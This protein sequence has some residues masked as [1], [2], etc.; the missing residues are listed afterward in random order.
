MT[1]EGKTALVTGAGSGIGRATAMEFA[2]AGASVALADLNQDGLDETC[3]N[4]KSV[5]QQV[6]AVQSDIGDLASIDAMIRSI[7]GELGHIDIVVNNAGVTR[8]GAL[9][10]ITEEIWDLMQRIN[11]KGTFFCMQGVARQM[12]EQGRGGRIINM[13]STGG[14]GFRGTSSPAYAAS[15]GAIISMTY[16]AAV[17]L[18]PHDINVNAICPGL[19]D[20]DMLRGML[21]QRSKDMGT[22][23]EQLIEGLEQIVPLGRLDE[24]EDIAAMAVFLAGPGGR[25]ITGQTINIDGGLVM[26]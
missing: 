3:A 26:N 20:T 18:A 24:P 6:L 22:P 25:N 14:K 1:L 11:A 2:K 7:V 21:A 15:K 9:L 19:V 13:S 23:V 10:D 16:I 4:L 5:G 8:H 12:V 17:Q